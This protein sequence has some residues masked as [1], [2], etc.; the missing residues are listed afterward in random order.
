M[1]INIRREYTDIKEV[2]TKIDN[3][4]VILFHNGDKLT[5]RNNGANKRLRKHLIKNFAGD[6]L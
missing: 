3:T 5:L 1:Q 4:L 6:H 2:R